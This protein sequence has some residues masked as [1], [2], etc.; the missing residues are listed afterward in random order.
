MQNLHLYAIELKGEGVVN[1]YDERNI[2]DY[3]KYLESGSATILNDTIKVDPDNIL[4]I[5]ELPNI[6]LQHVE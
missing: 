1:Q 4:S 3:K 5:K 2:D 6:N